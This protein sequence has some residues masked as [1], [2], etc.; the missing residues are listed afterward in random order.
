MLFFNRATFVRKYL[1]CIEI[2][3]CFFYNLIMSLLLL[4]MYLTQQQQ[5]PFTASNKSYPKEISMQENQWQREGW[6]HIEPVLQILQ[7]FSGHKYIPLFIPTKNNTYMLPD[8]NLQCKYGTRL[9]KF[10]ILC[11]L[12]EFKFLLVNSQF[13]L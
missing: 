4:A 3:L 7:V 8:F 6:R 1:L 9:G 13:V 10:R 12:Q 5:V 11:L 2:W